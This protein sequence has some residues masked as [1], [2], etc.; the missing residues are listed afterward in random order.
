MIP[1]D[2]PWE[3]FVCL[4]ALRVDGQ[5]GLSEAG[6][7]LVPYVNISKIRI[8]NGDVGTPVLGLKPTRGKFGALPTTESDNH[9]HPGFKKDMGL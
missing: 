7:T 2:L 9:S 5:A 1:A 6:D 3:C 8:T 4:G